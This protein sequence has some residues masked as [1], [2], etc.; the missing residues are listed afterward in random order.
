MCLC[1]VVCSTEI[2]LNVFVVCST[3][4]SLNVLCCVVCST[5][6]SL[7]VFVLCCVQ[8]GD[9]SECVCVVLCAAQRS[10]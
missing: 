8:H 9:L 10:L 3:E 5:E 2:S 6:I 1:C 7:N 4:I